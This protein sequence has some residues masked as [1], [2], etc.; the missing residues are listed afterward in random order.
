MTISTHYLTTHYSLDM[1]IVLF[2]IQGSGKGTQAKKLAAEFGFTIFEAGAELRRIAAS[3]TPLGDKVKSFIDIGHLVPHEIIMQVVK[4]AVC[5]LPKDLT[6]VFDGIPRDLDQQRDFDVIMKECG[7]EFR[8]LHFVLSA[9]EGVARIAGRA[10]LEG[11]TDDANEETIRRRMALFKEKTMPVV[12]I[13]RQMGRV[14][15]V[16]AAQEVDQ[17]F[18]D[19][20][21]ALAL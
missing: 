13:Y 20:K 12:E 16:N 7:R 1:D 8:C 15:D 19:V 6:V 4:E 3:G 9:E 11:R 18:G 5:G 21:K 10:K 17:V 2:G 14:V